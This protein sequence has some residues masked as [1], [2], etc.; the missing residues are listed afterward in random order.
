MPLDIRSLS[1]RSREISVE[2]A[3]EIIRVTYAPAKVTPAW[4]RGFQEALKDEWRTRALVDALAEILVGWDLTEEGA[5]LPVTR[6]SLARLPLD[7][8]GAIFSAIMED[9][10][11]NPTSAGPSAAG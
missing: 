4:E 10:R 8:L 1:A 6:E 9:L 7:L 3:G 2:Y 5:P 11:P